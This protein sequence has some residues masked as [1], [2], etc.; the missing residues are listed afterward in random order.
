VEEIAEELPEAQATHN[1]G[2][3]VAM[4]KRKISR[5]QK[6]PKASTI[7]REPEVQISDSQPAEQDLNAQPS[8]G[9]KKRKKRKSIGQQAMRTKAKTMESPIQH[10]RQPQKKAPKSKAAQ[11]VE[12][13]DSPGKQL[14]QETEDVVASIEEIE[15]SQPIGTGTAFNI[16]GEDAGQDPERMT[17][18]IRPKTGKRKRNTLLAQP[19]KRTTLSPPKGN[20]VLKTIGGEPTAVPDPDVLPT[21]YRNNG[22]GFD[23]ADVGIA[24]QESSLDNI[25][26]QAKPKVRR[27]KRKSIGQQ[28]PKT[29]STDLATPVRAT[30]NRKPIAKPSAPVEH[31]QAGTSKAI[32]AGRKIRRSPEPLENES[33]GERE[34]SD[35]EEAELEVSQPKSGR[36]RPKKPTASRPRQK[37]TTTKSTKLRTHDSKPR[38]KSARASSLKIRNPP[39]NSIP[40]T[41]YGPPSPASTASNSDVFDDPLTTIAAPP[42]PTKTINAADVLSQICR[43]LIGKTATSLAERAD[44]DPTRRGEWKRK[45]RTVEMYQEELGAKLLQLTRVMNTNTSLNVQVRAATKE[46][47][48]L[49]KEIKELEE[50]TEIAK[51]RKE[52]VLKAK[53]ARELEELLSG[54]AGAVKR[55]W[56]LQKREEGDAG[57]GMV[58]VEG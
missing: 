16:E 4:K 36:G 24:E 43:E 22:I 13:F 23:S 42:P 1:D 3:G 21:S 19:R 53:K 54:I 44:E 25:E 41:I 56:E 46:V 29:R 8:S 49:K 12:S 30:G 26:Q 39:K 10:A 14:Q 40:I 52:E 33:E 28:R 17:G 34:V 45:R 20:R 18:K 2:E 7:Q 5:T 9:R 37:A 27:K 58:D 50:E 11:P 6:P 35:A 51:Q 15:Q 48:A 55:G 57:A 32:R 38:P 31:K 47:R